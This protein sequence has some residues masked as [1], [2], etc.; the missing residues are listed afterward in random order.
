M[1]LTIEQLEG[2]VEDDGSVP[3]HQ[4]CQT[5]YARCEGIATVA[6]EGGGHYV[7]VIGDYQDR[8]VEIRI[9]P[10]T[11]AAAGFIRDPERPWPEFVPEST[12]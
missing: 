3:S 9:L 7:A 8:F 11:L 2:D 6:C 5:D 1:P 12:G 10:E 4:G